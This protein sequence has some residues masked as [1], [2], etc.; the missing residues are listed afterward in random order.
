MYMMCKH[1]PNKCAC[2]LGKEAVPS[3]S[4]RTRL[5]RV[6]LPCHTASSEKSAEENAKSRHCSDIGTGR[7]MPPLSVVPPVD[8]VQL[9]P[10]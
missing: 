10:T 8:C 6:A 2:R 4:E 1:L 9:V 7:G 3:R 5:H